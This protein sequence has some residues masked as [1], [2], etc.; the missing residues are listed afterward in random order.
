MSRLVLRWLALVGS[1]ALMLA[2]A[3]AAQAAAVYAQVPGSPFAEQKENAWSVAF[4]PTGTLLATANYQSGGITMFMVDPATRTL[5]A[6]PIQTTGPH[7]T[8][9]AFGRQSGTTYLAVANVGGSVQLFT[10]SSSG[11]LGLKTTSPL[12]GIPTSVAF[13]PNGTLVAATT[14]NGSVE[15]YSVSSTGLTPLGSTSAGH[16]T[17][18]VAFSP[19]GKQLAVTLF[20]ADTVRM[21]SVASDGLL[22]ADG[23]P[24]STGGEPSAAAFSPSGGLLAVSNKYDDTVSMFKVNGTTGA[25]T[26]AGAAAPTGTTPTSVAFNPNGKLLATSNYNDDSVSLFS[27]NGTTGALTAV[28]GSPLP[29]GF[30]TYPDAVAFSPT[31]LLAAPAWTSGAMYVA[32]PSPP[33]AAIASPSAGDGPFYALGSSVA[34][35]FSCADSPFGLGLASCKDSNGSSAPSGHLLTSSLGRHTYSVTALSRDGQHAVAS[36]SY[37][38]AG[39]PV[40]TL[41]RP[42]SGRTYRL[43]AHVATTFSCAEGAGGLGLV[44]CA[45]S[46]GAGGPHGHL[47]TSSFGRHRYSV[48]AI[49]RD[50]LTTVKSITFR[51]AAPPSVSIATPMA[52]GHYS[53]GA[54]V[55]ARY[56]CHEGLGGSGIKS[57]HGSVKAG[58]AID[59]SSR[60]R[61]RFTVTAVSK[62]GL[63]KT[64]VVTYRVG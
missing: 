9:V 32:A 29:L 55:L 42:R 2:T 38:V 31:G 43:H 36:L 39:A 46:S 52:D 33:T 51:V 21:Y 20:G 58:H 44:T 49:S 27:V 61:H 48:T 14:S 15:M 17:S 30:L 60:G 35:R 16:D 56:G 19:N 4:D 8:S 1:A 63:R 62:D 34:T 5:T 47:D 12:S 3:T 40:V 50:G 37:R 57:C 10:V 24:T 23:S 22:T 6:L 7:P 41:H 26:S 13:S 25:L 11:G 59:T 54:H 64:L 53:R 28:A 45:D 18:S